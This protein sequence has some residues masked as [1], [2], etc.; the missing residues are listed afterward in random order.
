MEIQFMN[1][2]LQVPICTLDKGAYVTSYIDWKLSI[3]APPQKKD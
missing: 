2:A 1:F 3:I